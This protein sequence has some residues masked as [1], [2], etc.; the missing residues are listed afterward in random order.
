MSI[1]VQT[2]NLPRNLSSRTK[3]GKNTSVF[4]STQPIKPQRGKPKTLA[5]SNTRMSIEIL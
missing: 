1:E 5:C 4:V 2:Y 3:L